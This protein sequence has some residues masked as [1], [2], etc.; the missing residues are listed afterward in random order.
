MTRARELANFADDTA[1]LE[2]LTVSDIT[3]LTATATEINKIDGF[4]GDHNDLIYAKDLRATGVTTTEF[5]KLDG[6]TASASDIN[7]TVNQI[8]DSST[9]LNVDSN[10]LVV[11]KSANRVG[12][13]TN[14]L[15]QTLVV[16]TA[17]GGGI[18]IEN[19]AGN[20]YRCAVNGDDS[21]AVID[22]GTAERLRIDS[23]GNV[24]VGKDSSGADT[25][26]HEIF[27]NGAVWHTASDSFPL[28]LNR[29]NSDG[30]IIRLRKDN[31]TVG[32]VSVTSSGTTYNTTSDARLKDN[33]ETIT[34]GTDKLMAMNPIKHT[35]I[36]D[37]DAPAV[38]GFIA[39]EM[40]DVIPEAVSGEDGGDEMMSMDYGRITPVIVSALQDAHKKIEALES[41]INEMEAK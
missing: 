3:D 40:Q 22:S 39:Q 19:S 24:L 16:K 26:G 20:Q 5:D 28:F 12:I 1:G 32:T 7:S 30:E 6:L 15:D 17:D 25:V 35:W 13:G 18:A 9:D 2:T 38:H 8:T 33:I 4:T 23:S 31:S 37:P 10:T 34:D 11:D 14:L 27:A 21:F 36:A 29:K 41:K